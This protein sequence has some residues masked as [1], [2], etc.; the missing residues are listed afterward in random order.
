MDY[1]KW[2]EMSDYEFEQVV[3]D[4]GSDGLDWREERDSGAGRVEGGAWEPSCGNNIDGRDQIM[5]DTSGEGLQGRELGRTRDGNRGA[6]N[7][8]IS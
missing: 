3:A 7:T 5:A 8:W 6:G 2:E 1:A 4:S